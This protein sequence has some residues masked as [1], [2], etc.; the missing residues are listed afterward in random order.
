MKKNLDKTRVNKARLLEELKNCRGIVSLACERVGITRQTYHLWRS[1]DPE[2]KKAA[3]E[4]NEYQIDFVESKL[5]DKI[6]NGSDTAIIFYLKCKAKDRGY[7]EKQELDITSSIS[8]IKVEFG[9]SNKD[10]ENSE[11]E[12]LNG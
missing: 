1:N 10:D 11:P 7:V 12:Q 9:S 6:E 3:E 8:N 4:I 5:L 2:F